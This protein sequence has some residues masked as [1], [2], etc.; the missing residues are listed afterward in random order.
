MPLFSWH[1]LAHLRRWLFVVD[2]RNQR[3]E[4]SLDIEIG[5]VTKKI[6]RSINHPFSLDDSAAMGKGRAKSF[7]PA[8]KDKS[9]VAAAAVSKK[10]R[11]RKSTGSIIHGRVE[12]PKTERKVPNAVSLFP[13]HLLVYNH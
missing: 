12:T 10:A 13:I 6:R 4:A 9:K 8:G 3:S 7:R 2:N 11:Q 5:V 1:S